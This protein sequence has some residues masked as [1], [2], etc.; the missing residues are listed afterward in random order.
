[1]GVHEVRTHAV[2]RDGQVDPQRLQRG[3]RGRELGQ[4]GVRG[5]AGLV[6]R[7]AEAADLHVDITAL[8]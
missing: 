1:M 7:C 4:V 8:P 5:R 2:G 3:V 6:A